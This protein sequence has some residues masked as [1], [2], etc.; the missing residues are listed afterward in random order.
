MP[1]L[2]IQF[3]SLNMYPLYKKGDITATDNY[4]QL[5]LTAVLC[6]IIEGIVREKVE[7]YFHENNLLVK[8]QHSFGKKKSLCDTRLY[9][10]L[11]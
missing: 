8:Q 7:N 1:L 9:Y 5:S 4:R 6:K 2:P 3:E 10:V 11:S